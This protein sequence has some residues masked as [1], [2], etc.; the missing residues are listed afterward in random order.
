MEYR[1]TTA[2]EETL[3]QLRGTVA[4]KRPQCL[5]GRCVNAE[6]D[7]D[8]SSA[9]IRPPTTAGAVN[10]ASVSGLRHEAEWRGQFVD[11]ALPECA[12]SYWNWGQFSAAP[13]VLPRVATSNSHCQC[14]LMMILSCCRRSV[15]T[16]TTRSSLGIARFVGQDRTLPV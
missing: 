14:V 7:A 15:A 6:Q 3:L 16:A 9:Y 4:R 2:G 5:A 10:T 1:S 13:V 11:E 8:P 12:E